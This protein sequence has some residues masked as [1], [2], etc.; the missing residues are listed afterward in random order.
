M[1][2]SSGCVGTAAGCFLVTFDA[3]FRGAVVIYVKLIE[4]LVLRL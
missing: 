2:S 3:F 4:L 1:N